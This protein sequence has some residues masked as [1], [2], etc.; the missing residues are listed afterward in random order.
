MFKDIYK[1]FPHSFI[2]TA[3]ERPRKKDLLAKIA[4]HFKNSE[5]R[6][7]FVVFWAWI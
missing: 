5:G 3:K 6:V 4:N 2:E 1:D 7:F